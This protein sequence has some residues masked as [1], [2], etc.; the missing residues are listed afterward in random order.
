[1]DQPPAKSPRSCLTSPLPYCVSITVRWRDALIGLALAM[2]VQAAAT[3]RIIA[4]AAF[5]AV[6][7]STRATVQI[8]Q[9]AVRRIAVSGDP[10]LVRCVTASVRDGHLV[11]GWGEGRGP[12]ERAAVS[13]DQIVVTARPDCP[14]SG[15][16]KRLVIHASSPV[17]D[18]VEISGQGFVQVA[19]LRTQAFAATI[20]GRG[21]ITIDG[22]HAIDTRMAIAGIGRVVA[23]G[24]V[25]RLAIDVAGRGIVDTRA[26]HARA[27]D[28]SVEGIGNIA[29]TVDGPA[30]GT[31]AGKGTIAIGGHPA[32]A[33]RRT[34]D[35]H[36]DCPATGREGSGR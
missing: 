18:S 23:S 30:S 15:D 11:I 17:I 24:E 22:L 16:P 31:L 9:A 10:R 32:C 4:V 28:I 26:A 34:G 29:A 8:K 5:H 19:P 12:G 36:I 6:D 25:G 3:D 7:L 1:M 33:I 21:T 35:G 27:I 13:G 14:P 20:S 2:M